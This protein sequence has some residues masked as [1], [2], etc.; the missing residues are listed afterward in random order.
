[1]KSRTFITGI[2]DFHA[3][4]ISIMKI[5]YTKSNPK[6]KF[7]RDYKNFDNDLSKV[8]LGNSLRNLTIL[9]YTGFEKVFLRTLDC[10]API[11][12][13][14]LRVNENSFMSQDLRKAIIMHSIMKNLYLKNKTDLN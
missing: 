14:I 2:S 12:E 4:T 1:M 7:Y 6:I 8:D 11:K 13:K 9:T 5:I 10:H 3:L